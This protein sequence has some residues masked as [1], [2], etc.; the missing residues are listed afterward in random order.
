VLER[1]RI[2]PVKRVNMVDLGCGVGTVARHFADKL[3]RSHITAVT[4][5]E[6]QVRK[7]D[8]LNRQ[9][10]LDGK[11]SIAKTNFESLDFVDETFTHAYALESS[12]YAN[13][14]GK[15]YFISEL[16]RVLQP[17]G[18]FCIADGFIRHHQKLPWLFRKLYNK[19]T[20]YWAVPCFG[21][22]IDFKANLEKNGFHDIKVEKI[23]W[24]IA[25]SVLYVPW[26]CLKFFAKEIWKNKSLRMKKERWHNV[27]APVLGMMMGIYMRHF[28]YYIVSGEKK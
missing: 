17:G 18:R 16:S 27:F 1:L 6:Y 9:Q 11:V 10:K 25:P 24:K 2:D 26:T 23:T 28:G 7:C 4:I 12:C 14:A 5:S 8:Q 20:R 15:D 13:S 19:V 21:N 3:P 22:I